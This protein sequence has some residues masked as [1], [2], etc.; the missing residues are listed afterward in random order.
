ML[1]KALCEKI[2]SGKLNEPLNKKFDSNIYRMKTKW[3]ETVILSNRP[4][5]I[6][7]VFIIISI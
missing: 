5:K 2:K 1:N 7:Y 4:I 6:V 3:L